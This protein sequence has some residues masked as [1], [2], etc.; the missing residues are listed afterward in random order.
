MGL[1]SAVILLCGA[2]WLCL[3]FSMPLSEAIMI[4]VL[5]FV[6]V[7]A[8]KVGIAVTIARGLSSPTT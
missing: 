5:P 4:G 3:A 8:V 2:A 7:D 1:G 6:A